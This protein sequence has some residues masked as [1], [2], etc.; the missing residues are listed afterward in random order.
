MHCNHNYCSWL[1]E[2][3]SV[4]NP[5]YYE[6]TPILPT[7]SPPS[8]YKFCPPPPIS[9]ICCLVS[10]TE[11]VKV[12]DLL[13]YLMILWIC[14][15]RAL[16]PRYHKDLVVCFLQQ[17]VCLLRSN[18]RR[19]FLLVLWFD[20]THIQRYTAHTGANRLTY[21]YKHILTPPV[22]CS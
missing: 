11:C 18:I 12:P 13:L 7:P 14:T 15:C 2:G 1:A 17:G 16:A 19:V 22:M 3:Q 9:S 4:P 8:F 20:I 10:L 6:K 5:V 21:P